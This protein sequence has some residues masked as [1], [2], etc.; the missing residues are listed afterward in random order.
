MAGEEVSAEQPK[1]EIKATKNQKSAEPTKRGE[2]RHQK[3]SSRGS[4]GFEK[5]TRP[6]D[7]SVPPRAATTTHQQG[8]NESSSSSSAATA[9]ASNPSPTRPITDL[10]DV[11]IKLDRFNDLTRG[12]QRQTLDGP[13]PLPFRL[14]EHLFSIW[15]FAFLCFC[16]CCF[17]PLGLYYGLTDGTNMRSGKQSL[18]LLVE[19][20]KAR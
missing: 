1:P 2:N 19:T 14:R 16:E 6:V 13:P 9:V 17:V 10:K 11:N 3:K 12:D 18:M 8:K 4:G 15:F 20:R 5:T 7:I